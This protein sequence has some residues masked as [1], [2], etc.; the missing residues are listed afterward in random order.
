MSYIK[1]YNETL[2]RPYM[3]VGVVVKSKSP[4]MN[5]SG[6]ALGDGFYFTDQYNTE[7][8]GTPVVNG[9]N[10][11]ISL[12]P[13]QG[14]NAGGWAPRGN[15]FVLK[16][17]GGNGIEADEILLTN[18]LINYQYTFRNNSYNLFKL[19]PDFPS[20]A[21]FATA[22]D[23]TYVYSGV[24]NP[25]LTITA[26][27]YKISN[28]QWGQQLTFNGIVD[29]VAIEWRMSANNN[30]LVEN[31]VVQG[32]GVYAAYFAENESGNFSGFVFKSCNFGNNAQ[33]LTGAANQV[34]IGNAKN[35][36]M[37][38]L[39]N[40]SGVVDGDSNNQ[41]GNSGTGGGGGN[42]DDTSDHIDVPALP[43]LSATAAGFVTLYKPTL[44]NLLDLARYLWSANPLNVLIQYFSNP[45]DIIIGLGIVPV[46]APANSSGYPSAGTIVV[47]FSIP[48]YDSQYYEYDC[49]SIQLM[50]FWGS[51]LDYSPYTSADIYLPYIGVRSLDVDEVMGKTIGVKY[52][53][54]LYGG[55]VC[56]FVTVDGSVRY[57]FTGNCI[58]QVPVNA[59]NY[60][61][62]VQNLISVACV[63]GTGIAAAGSAGA[64]AAVGEEASALG[65]GSATTAGAAAKGWVGSEYSEVRALGFKEWAADGGG[66]ALANCTMSTVM[67]AKPVVERTGAVN[68]TNGQ[69]AVQ[70]P[71]ITLRRPRQSLAENYKHYNGYPSNIT[72]KLGDLNGYTKVDSIRI[73]DLAATEPELAEIYSLLK[74]GVII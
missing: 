63:V 74:K 48:I 18:H 46:S 60:D 37:A 19:C 3:C 52:H 58:Q 32:T 30:N 42:F 56:A 50:E 26:R 35:G 68:A 25:Q 13:S 4:Q 16:N 62:L 40:N 22:S 15:A 1:L 17:S 31:F 11:S 73:N 14:A 27:T 53:I 6:V 72:A 43:S 20:A 44:S 70:T 65:A 54:D 38:A 59:A 36:W 34:R 39:L 12:N 7:V 71:F 64:A 51:A 24:D 8:G 49:G 61:A 28:T 33:L 5:V 67:S 23:Q 57:Q 47:P 69:L 41:G 55:A 9:A 66:T 2:Q 21:N 45:M 29:G 10:A